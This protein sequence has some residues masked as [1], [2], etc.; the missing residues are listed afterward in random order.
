MLA[1]GIM[2]GGLIQ[3]VSQG[4]VDVHITGDPEF[5]FWKSVYRRHTRFSRETLQNDFNEKPTWGST[6]TCN[7]IK[8]ADLLSKMYLQVALPKLVDGT[9]TGWEGNTSY[10]SRKAVWVNSI[11]HRLIEQVDLIIGGELIDSQYGLW[12]E[13]W[14]EL[15]QTKSIENMVFKN[16]L[17]GET[18]DL[19]II[20]LNFWFCKNPGSALPLI[21]LEESDIIV[22][23]QFAS[24]A[25]CVQV[26]DSIT[27]IPLTGTFSKVISEPEVSIKLFSDYIYTEKEESEILATGS[28]YLM[29]QVQTCEFLNLKKGTNVKNLPFIH[30][31]KEI[32]W[33]TR[34]RDNIN[35]SVK[36]I[37]QNDF[38]NFSK[39]SCYDRSSTYSDTLLNN[40]ISSRTKFVFNNKDHASERP[41]S[42]YQLMQAYKH[43]S[44]IP[45]NPGI[46]CYNFGIDPEEYQP[47]GSINLTR[48]DNCKMI[49]DVV[50]PENLPLDY[51]KSPPVEI[52]GNAQ[53][54]MIDANIFA[55][56][57]NIFK[58]KNGVGGLLY[59]K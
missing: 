49:L 21:A 58:V 37:C 26:V 14:S 6:C 3:L 13:I 15:S 36:D 47:S 19:M 28:E 46:F 55:L 20:P 22:K 8:K 40:T 52:A 30:P 34:R 32:I 5:S 24:F 27:G 2:S 10:N 48:I 45:E 57:Y 38:F 4:A 41:A 43:H 35:T 51:S 50:Y 9:H 11:G 44:C 53:D 25:N 33:V 31:V 23:F 18:S 39:H 12:M 56:G 59:K 16:A 29:E 17:R 54:I 1:S 7:I 42:Y